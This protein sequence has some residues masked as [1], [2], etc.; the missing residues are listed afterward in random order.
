MGFCLLNNAA[1]AAGYG[2]TSVDRVAI[3]DWDAH[4]GNGTQNIFYSSDRV[5]YCSIHQEDTFPHTGIAGETGIGKGA[6]Y[7]INVPLPRLSGI[8]EYYCAFEH[9][10]IPALR[11]FR[12]GLIL[13]SAGQDT[14][15]DD[16]VGRMRLTP[17]DIGLLAGIMREPDDTPFSLVLEGGYGPSHPEAIR[18]IF[19]ALEGHVPLHVPPPASHDVQDRIRRIAH[20]HRL[21]E[22]PA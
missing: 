16:P 8:A 13:I 3:V 5:L 1:V 2:L 10:I 21:P 18:Q 22:H 14:L 12:P 7:T 17:Q 4:H 9:I 15:A 19:A 11:R 20:L 6:G